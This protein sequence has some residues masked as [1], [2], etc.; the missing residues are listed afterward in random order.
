[1]GHIHRGGKEARGG[2]VSAMPVATYFGVVVWTLLPMR[3]SSTEALKEEKRTT[4]LRALT[5]TAGKRALW[6]I[7]ALQLSR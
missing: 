2:D 3:F 1:M 4:H 6:M 5:G 7:V